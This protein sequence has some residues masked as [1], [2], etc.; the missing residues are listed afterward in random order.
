[1]SLRGTEL[2]LGCKID[3]LPWICREVEKLRHSHFRIDNQFVFLR[4]H[5]ALKLSIPAETASFCVDDS[6]LMRLS[7]LGNSTDLGMG[8][9]A[10][11]HVVAKVE[12]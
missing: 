12:C 5:G 9:P 1:M 10:S 11:S 8:I 7:R 4:A 6:P 3:S 2:R